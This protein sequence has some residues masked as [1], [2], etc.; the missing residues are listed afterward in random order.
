MRL[1][2]T[3]THT[4][5]R[6]VQ[7]NPGKRITQFPS[8]CSTARTKAH[9]PRHSLSR[10]H[11]TNQSIALSKCPFLTTIYSTPYSKGKRGDHGAPS[12]L[13]RGLL[14][15]QEVRDGKDDDFS[16]VPAFYRLALLRDDRPV[17]FHPARCVL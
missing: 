11:H 12:T 6:A 2:T 4:A 7:P 5:G 1:K 16:L 14:S 3:H 17:L 15:S 8:L 10:L 9:R 13:E